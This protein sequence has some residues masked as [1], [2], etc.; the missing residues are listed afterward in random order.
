MAAC[1]EGR[2][3]IILDGERREEGTTWKVK[4]GT[5]WKVKEG[6]PGTPFSPSLALGE[7]RESVRVLLTKNHP[8]PTSTFR[9]GALAWGNRVTPY[10]MGLIT[11]TVKTGST[12]VHCIVALHAVMC[13]CT[14]A[15]PFGNKRRDFVVYT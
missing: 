10:Y 9:V 7:A 13:S 6:R 5:T 12:S 4:E 8:V 1:V 14:S 15:Y 3:Q 11:P 2:N